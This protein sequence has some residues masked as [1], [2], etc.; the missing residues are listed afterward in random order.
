MY[1]NRLEEGTCATLMMLVPGFGLV[2]L[3]VPGTASGTVDGSA[4][5]DDAAVD[6][7]RR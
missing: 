1:G 5:D 7:S 3:L 4:P 2:P 6:H